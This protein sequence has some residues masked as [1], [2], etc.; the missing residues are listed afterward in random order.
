VVLNN[1]IEIAATCF[2]VLL[3]LFFI[4]AGRFVSA[5]DWIARRWRSRC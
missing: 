3:A 5:D 4:E 1:R 2:A